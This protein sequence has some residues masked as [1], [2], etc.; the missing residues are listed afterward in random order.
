MQFLFDNF[1]TKI[2]I[3]N[4]TPSIDSIAHDLN[5]II[6][7]ADENTA[8][9]AK[10]ICGRNNLPC[11][12]IKSGEENKNWQSVELI[13][14]AAN[15]AGLDRN[16]IFIAVGG[17]VIC[18]LSGFA[19]SIYKR[20]CRL[21]LVCTTLLSMVD[22]SV[23]GKTGFNLFNIRNLA[24]TFFPAQDV[25]MP[26]EVLSTLPQ[27]EWKS[28]LGELIKTA[29][30]SGEE[31]QIINNKEQIINNKNVDFD[32]LKNIIEKA[33]EFKGSIVN[34]DFRETGKRRLLN[35][36]H[37]FGHALESTAG[38][39]KITHGEAVVWGICRACELGQTLGIT[40]DKRRQKIK[41]MIESF[42]FESSCPH[43][44]AGNTDTLFTAMNSD[45]KK[46]KDKLVFI[47]PDEKSARSVAIESEKD[48]KTLNKIL[49]GII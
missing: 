23:G 38:F 40:P 6:L 39:G 1:T 19:A 30:L 48:M 11:C 24:G 29:I 32:V 3:S 43:P 21:V 13:L 7:I 31:E 35:L 26:L 14:S 15:N 10:K 17:G 34:E 16:G 28:G 8:E 9:Y 27:R 5:N 47:V 44:L 37:T 42:N 33:V 46:E 4:C 45:K 41:N 18:D 20:G 2:K 12:I 49:S 25:Y 36:G 22:A